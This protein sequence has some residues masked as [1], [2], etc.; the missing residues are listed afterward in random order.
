MPLAVL[1]ISAEKFLNSQEMHYLIITPYSFFL[2]NQ[3]FCLAVKWL[4]LFAVVNQL[5]GVL[6]E[7]NIPLISRHFNTFLF[8]VCFIAPITLL[9]STAINKM[10]VK[11]SESFFRCIPKY[12]FPET[13]G[14]LHSINSFQRCLEWIKKCPFPSCRRIYVFSFQ[15]GLIIRLF[16][17]GFAVT[18]LSDSLN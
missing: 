5:F 17:L 15:T 14:F 11:S 4:L 12:S 8:K 7:Q 16:F 18:L 2:I 10:A 3:L 13:V 6:F 9:L 1:V